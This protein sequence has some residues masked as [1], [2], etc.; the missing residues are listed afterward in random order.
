MMLARDLLTALGVLA[1]AIAVFFVAEGY[2]VEARFFPQLIAGVLVL[3]AVAMLL[4]TLLRWRAGAKEDFTM[5]EA[6]WRVLGVVVLSALYF[7]ALSLVGFTLASLVFIPLTAWLFGYRKLHVT[8]PLA[9]SFVVA[10]IGLLNGILG[11][12][13]PPDIILANI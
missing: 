13:M 11:L 4:R 10:L 5:F 1:F 12:P 9:L 3:L 6:P 2:T 7:G 8:V